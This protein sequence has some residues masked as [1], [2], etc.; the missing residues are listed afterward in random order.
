M[1]ELNIEYLK[2]VNFALTNNGI[3]TCQS[4]TMKNLGEDLHDV[5]VECS[6]EYFT[7]TRS[8]VIPL[9]PKGEVM[10]LSDFCI[11]PDSEKMISFTESVNTTFNI[12][13]WADYANEE[14]RQEVFANDYDI[15]L[16]AYD[17]WLG[18]DILPQSLSAFV[19]PNHPAISKVVVDAA[20]ILKKVTGQSSFNEY[21]TRNPDDVLKQVAAVYAAI[22]K[23]GIVYRALPASFEQSGQRITLPYQVLESKLGNCVELTIL[24][25]SVLEAIGINTGLIIQKGHAFLA[26]WLVDDCYQHGICD[27]A[28]FIEKK[29]SK[30]IN[31]MIVLETTMATHENTAFDK[32]L[33]TAS[34]Q[35]ADMAKFQMMIDVKRCRLENYRPMPCRVLADGCWVLDKGVEHDSC[36]IDIKEC[37]RYDLSSI[38][39]IGARELSRMDIWERK[40][41]DFSLRNNMLNLYLR[42]KAIQLISF[43]VDKLEDQ[44]QDGR[45]FR[46]IEKPDVDLKFDDSDRLVHSRL[47]P[48]LQP[49]VVDDLA[50]DM[51]HTYHTEAETKNTL[52]NIYR[53]ARNAIEETGA[54][55]LFLAIGTLRW[56]E[57]EVSQT[58]RYAP[59]LMLPVE[60]VYKKG[61]FFIRTRDEDIMLNV[62]LTELLRQNYGIDVPVLSNLPKDNHGVDVQLIFT[63]LR[64]SLKEQKRWDVEEECILGVFSFSKFLMWNDIHNHRKELLENKVI[65]SLVAQR[66]TW[67]PDP[68][69]STLREKDKQMRPDELALPVAVDSSQMAAVFEAG[70]GHSFI[71]YGPPGTGK[72]QTITNLIANALFQGKRVL[73]VAEKMAALSVVQR[74]LAKIGLDPFCLEMHSNKVTKRHILDQFAKALG[75]THIKSPED[76]AHTAEKLYAERT[77]LIEYMEALHESKGGDGFSLHDCI[78][79]YESKDCDTWD[80]DLTPTFQHLTPTTQADYEHLLGG[81][82]ESVIKLVGQPSHHALVGLGIE[83]TDLANENTLRSSLQDAKAVLENALNVL[84]TLSDTKNLHDQLLRDNSENIFSQDADALHREWMEVRAKWFIPRFFAKRSFLSKMRQFSPYIIEADVEKV[85][86]KL[87]TYTKQHKQICEVQRVGEKYFGKTYELDAL[88]S[89]G[90]IETMIVKLGQWNDN[91][92]GSRDWYQWCQFRKEAIEKGL[93]SLIDIIEHREV[94][95]SKVLDM[96][97]KTIFMQLAKKKIGESAVLRTFEG[98]IFDETVSL[99]KKLT[100]DFQMLSQKELYAKLAARVPRVTDNI[101][102]SSEIGLLNRNISN[103]GR[104]LSLRD[105]MDQIPTLMPRLCPC[106]LMSPMSVAQ[107]LSLNQDKFDL[108]IFD[109][110]SQMPTSEA[111]G[112]IARGKALIVVGDPK[113]MPPTSFF[114]STNVDE[115]EAEIDDLE[116]IL[117]DCRTLDIPS[118]Q[119]NWHYRS[120]HESLI[121]FS[122]NEYYEGSLITF[123][124]VDDQQT[125]VKLVPVDGIY[126]KGGKRSNKAE[127]EAIVNEI[128]R[129]LKGITNAENMRESAPS[130]RGRAGGEVTPSSIG[131]IAFSVVQQ[132]LIEDILQER[133]ES[134]KALRE[135]AD[136]LYE[137][138]FV[139]NLENVQGDERDVI[140]FSIGYGPDK[141]GRVSMNFGPLNNKGGERRLNVAVSRAR[142]EMMVFSTLKSSQIDLRR[143]NARGVEGLKH[144]LE[145]AEQQILIQTESSIRCGNDTLIAQ[146]IANALNEKGY[147]ASVNIGRSQFK[148][149]VAVSRKDQ[150]DVYQLGILLDGEGYHSTQTTRDREIVQTSVLG[151]LRWQVMRV[152]SVDWFNNPERV[153]SRIIERITNEESQTSSPSPNSYRPTPVFDISSE[154]EEEVQ[155]NAVEY[156]ECDL[157]VSAAKKLSDYKLVKAI[158]EVEQPMSF[159]QLCRRVSALREA[160]RV[161]PTIQNS[162]MEVVEKSMFL[163]PDRKGFTVWFTEEACHDYM[164]YRPASGRDVTDI[165]M[166]EI[167]N[168]VLEAVTEQFSINADSLSLIAAKKLGFTRRGTN[169]D[170]ALTIAT[171]ELCNEGRIEIVDGI[172][173]SKQ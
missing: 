85:L 166:A 39:V 117:E 169:V 134:D 63:M 86:D 115:E 159:M 80:A 149:D 144:F 126:D 57:N 164:A 17:Q 5:C 167:K 89:K 36:S 53:A 82:F 112:A 91:L 52:K 70:L 33:Q 54:N 121:A 100:T 79:R 161:T 140:L 152:W 32:A 95:A 19:M 49:L 81:R 8:A 136:E 114:S 158:L 25:A 113:Q 75:V 99:Y 44:L 104:G 97:M 108:V 141:T 127:A 71:L 12:K 123:P 47:Y 172:L 43:E 98:M 76:Y 59:I 90:E 154:K 66:L 26:V 122:N 137:P 103:G 125:K 30:G 21:Q 22:H 88:P 120:Q 102:S 171:R 24:F 48:S 148:V 77:K 155:S 118:L 56:Y 93:S 96:T 4:L 41:L 130:L 61:G 35:L 129:R 145:Y 11:K 42:Q 72:S 69:T 162:I 107:Y 156:K 157:S 40:L 153:I 67:Q 28:S 15:R 64:D 147:Q 38:K 138:I 20:A 160:P 116:S 7:L 150:P 3:A 73:F 109:E 23:Q 74:R 51:L 78:L 151:N 14:N 60:M 65:E 9:L 55:S 119:L 132:N 16:L 142:Q 106:M 46:I 128:E 101:D 34:A 58:P 94:D 1:I 135:A 143:T 84:P 13:V 37:S 2:G 27:D 139:K 133:L 173:H 165:P 31:E 62:T 163:V 168:V 83:E 131:V 10:R 111:I 92:G 45:E 68:L 29:C 146:Q 50:H 110:A 124:S 170:E 18:I 87:S 6:G 105:L